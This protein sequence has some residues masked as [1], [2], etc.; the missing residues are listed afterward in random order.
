MKISGF[1]IARNVEKL[2]YPILE[3]INSILS[4][5][6]EFIINI[7]DSEDNTLQLIEGISSPKIKIVKTKWFYDCDLRF[8]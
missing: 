1:T 8:F 4:I 5:C 7:G 6:D 2:Q 3:S